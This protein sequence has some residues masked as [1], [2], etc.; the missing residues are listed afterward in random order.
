M[1]AD[2]RRDRIRDEVSKRPAVR[3]PPAQLTAGQSEM[4]RIEE[5]GSI[6]E[7]RQLGGQ[8]LRARLRI[9]V[10]RGDDQPRQLDH[11][12]GLPP[13]HQPEERLRGQDE[14]EVVR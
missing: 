13:G 14:D 10:A 5:G 8:E 11:P 12:A 1:V 7:V 2:I 9:S 3:R 4:R 6:G